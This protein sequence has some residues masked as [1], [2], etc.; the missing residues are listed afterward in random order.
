MPELFEPTKIQTRGQIKFFKTPRGSHVIVLPTCTVPL[1]HLVEENWLETHSEGRMRTVWRIDTLK[2]GSQMASLFAKEPERMHSIEKNKYGDYWNRHADKIKVAGLLIERQATWEARILLGLAHANIPAEKPQAI[3]I[4]KDGT[5][6]VIT[7]SVH[8]AAPNNADG[9][10]QDDAENLEDRAKECGFEP[11]DL[12]P[13]NLVTDDSGVAHII[14]VNR[15][16]WPPYTDRYR[17]K[18][19]AAIEQ[20]IAKAQG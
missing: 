20:A 11:I 3:V 18:F 14:D 10:F 15:W 7:K 13:S 1:A 2:N 5:R 6:F 9:I 8:H 4:R 17:R 16:N 19:I 12:Y